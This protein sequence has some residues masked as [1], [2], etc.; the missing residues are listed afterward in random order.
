MDRLLKPKVI[1]SPFIHCY[2]YI[3]EHIYYTVRAENESSHCEKCQTRAIIIE[4]EMPVMLSREKYCWS[5]EVLRVQLQK[6]KET[7][8]IESSAKLVSSN[9]D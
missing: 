5:D 8:K 2:L 1:S 9:T 6:K 7:F 3:K 4:N